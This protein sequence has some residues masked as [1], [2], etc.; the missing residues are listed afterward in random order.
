MLTF[1]ITILFLN[2]NIDFSKTMSRNP[3]VKLP[4]ITSIHPIHPSEAVINDENT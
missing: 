1:S 3:A 4:P 2:D